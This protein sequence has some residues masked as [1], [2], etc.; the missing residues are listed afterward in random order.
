LL[1]C[2]RVQFS[3]VSLSLFLAFTR[4]LKKFYSPRIF[5]S[6]SLEVL[7]PILLGS[8]FFYTHATQGIHRDVALHRYQHED[9]QA[10]RD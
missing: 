9:A 5:A 8:T 7:P 4:S 10:E 2:S 6:H 1:V 3:C